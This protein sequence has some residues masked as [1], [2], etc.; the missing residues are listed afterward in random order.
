M[1]PIML[2]N[3]LPLWKIKQFFISRVQYKEIISEVT[4]SKRDWLRQE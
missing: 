4:R 1:F 3:Y 2:Q